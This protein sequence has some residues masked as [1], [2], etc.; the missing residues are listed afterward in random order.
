MSLPTI[1]TKALTVAAVAVAVWLAALLVHHFGW[2]TIVE[3]KTLDHRFQRYA[4]PAKAGQDIVLVAVDEVSLEAFGRWPWPRDRFGYL[5]RYLKEAGA[6]AVVFDILFL[7]PDEAGPEFDE[8]FVQ[9]VRAA[10][11]VVL[12]YLLDAPSSGSSPGSFPNALVPLE[13]QS[14][15][16]SGRLPRH[17]G[18]KLP[19]FEL[20]RAA[21]GLGY[22][23]LSPDPDGT[24]RRIFPLARAEKGAFSQIAVTTA[25]LVLGGGPAALGRRSLQLGTATIPLTAEGQLLLDWHGSLQDRTYPAYSAGAVLQSF[26][27]QQRGVRPLLEPGLFKDKIVFVGATAAGTYDLKV[28]PLS[29]FTAGVLIHM[30]ALDNML[31]NR[32][33]RPASSWAFV[34]GT[35]LLC[36]STASAFILSRRPLLKVGLAI[37]VV[38]AYYGLVVHAFTSHGLWMELALPT[39]AALLTFTTA[40]TLEYFTEGRKRRQLRAVFDRFM[41]PEVVQEI[42]RDPERIELG[43]ETRVLSVL[44]TDV[45]GFTTLSEKLPPQRLVE[46]INRYLSAMAGVILRHRGNVNKYLGDGIMAIFGAPAGDPAHA[47]LACYAALDCQAALAELREEGRRQGY[48]DLVTRIGIN[49]GP[50][51]VG[52]MGSQ[53]R[54][55]YTAMGDSVNLASRLEGANKYYGTLI[56]LG[57]QT[58]DQ[59]KEGVEAREI[60]LLR[61]K[62]KE[63]PV[64]VYELLGRRGGLEVRQRQLIER[65]QEGLIAYKRR[66]FQAAKRAFEAALRVDPQD[67]PSQVYRERVEA[68]L[69]SPPPPSW[70]GVYDL[71]S[72]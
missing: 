5:V 25:R 71:Q 52:Y 9:E 44:F 31:R 34:L 69:R 1:P 43:G 23:D 3:L 36:L 45:A 42:L 17:E 57:P 4:D 55:E 14:E 40:A 38:L 70:N 62:G 2:T 68:F 29:P 13:V 56:L 60:D 67:G 11:N 33:M 64:A 10:G 72:K 28:T 49:S 12:P 35:L 48:P 66:D 16:A 61:V 63:E 15:A 7:E 41:A 51:V 18:G 20:A 53:A 24:M 37:G 54:M 21:K 22:I 59:A 47:T 26:V 8:V 6:K 65:Y 58:Y 39:G 32:Y 27:Q 46:L 19:Y 50:L 30:T